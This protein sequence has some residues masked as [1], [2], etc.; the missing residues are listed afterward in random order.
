[1]KVLCLLAALFLGGCGAVAQ[2]QESPKTATLRLEYEDGGV[3][4]GTAV[5][6]HTVLTATHCMED[7]EL[8]AINGRVAHVIHREDDGKDHALVVV[9]VEFAHHVQMGG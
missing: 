8:R 5:G 6:R 3:C 7:S 2:P 9:S 4:S 1:M